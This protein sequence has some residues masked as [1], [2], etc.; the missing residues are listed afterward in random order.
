MVVGDL[1]AALFLFRAGQMDLIFA[2]SQ[3]FRAGRV[4][5]PKALYPISD[6]VSKRAGQVNFAMQGPLL[7]PNPR[8]DMM[9]V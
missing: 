1:R 4:K 2:R 5:T 8:L 7:G 3:M 9:L 6:H